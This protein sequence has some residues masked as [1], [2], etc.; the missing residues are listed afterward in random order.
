MTATK[1]MTL[2]PTDSGHIDTGD[3]TRPR[4]DAA[5]PFREIIPPPGHPRIQGIE[6]AD[7]L[8]WCDL[9]RGISAPAWLINRLDAKN[10]EPYKGFTTDGNVREGIYNYADDEGAPMEAM[11]MAA[12]DMLL[13][14]TPDQRAEVQFE[15]V[16]VD[17]FRLWSNPELYVNPGEI[18]MPF[19][20]VVLHGAQGLPSAKCGQKNPRV[21]QIFITD[22]RRWPSAG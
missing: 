12:E 13:T 9:K 11:M 7:A 8:S 21:C 4:S 3:P 19:P 1:T 2:P 6:T 16:D 17:E 20:L 22:L 14:L 5:V 15:S 18:E 10:L